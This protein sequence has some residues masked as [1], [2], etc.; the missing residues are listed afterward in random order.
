MLNAYRP[1]FEHF[2]YPLGYRIDKPKSLP[3]FPRPNHP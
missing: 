2:V 1:A 3:I